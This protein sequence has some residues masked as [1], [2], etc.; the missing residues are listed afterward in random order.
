VVIAI[1][2]VAFTAFCVW[3]VVRI[4]NRRERWAKWAAVVLVS[5]PV[6]YV[7]STGPV[8][9]YCRGDGDLPGWLT[10]IYW[11]LRLMPDG[12]EFVE[13]AF[14]WYIGLWVR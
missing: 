14:D 1:F 3:L 13:D 9:W 7:L 11:P 4:V 8:V 10:I 2:G 6:L 12:P 5:T